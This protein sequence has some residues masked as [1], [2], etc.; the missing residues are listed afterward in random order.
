M[1]G[2]VL[3]SGTGLPSLDRHAPGYLLEGEG[4]RWLIDCGSGTLLQLERLQR[5]FHTLDGAFITHTHADHIGDLTPL[6][7]ALRFHGLGREKPFYLF[8]PP[9]F[10]DF[11]ARIIAPVVAPPD[12]FPF[13]VAEMVGEVSV[14]GMSVHAHPTLHSSRMASVAYR[15][16]QGGKSVVFSG[17]CDYEPGLIAFARGADLLVLDCS[18]LDAG[19]IKGHLS[20]GLAGLVAAQAGVG[21]L[22]PTHFYPQA[23]GDDHRLAECRIHFTGPIQLAEDLQAFSV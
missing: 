7:H 5:G 2:F 11:F 12:S 13:H 19:K 23:A 16:Q 8:G 3:G 1:K 15:F 9:G 17:D 21:R 18:T 22:L 10:Q 4:T 6:V 14:V 20:A